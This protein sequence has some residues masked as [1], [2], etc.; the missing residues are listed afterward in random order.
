MDNETPLPIKSPVNPVTIRRVKKGEQDQR[1]LTLS[2]F[3]RAFI[4][5][6]GIIIREDA[7]QKIQ[8]I[9]LYVRDSDLKKIKKMKHNE[10]FV[11]YPWEAENEPE[12]V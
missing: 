3:C 6:D 5:E 7:G 10:E 11:V 2:S 8:G 12:E 4:P 1:T 9:P